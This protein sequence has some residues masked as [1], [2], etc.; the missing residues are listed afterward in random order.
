MASVKVRRE[1]VEMKEM[2]MM[3]PTIELKD[4][5]NIINAAWN[6]LCARLDLDKI[7]IAEHRWLPFNR[8]LLNYTNRYATMTKEEKERE[9][10]ETSLVILPSHKKHDQFNKPVLPIFNAELIIVP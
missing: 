6:E 5:I 1:I 2:H 9:G 4:I 10:S 3:L 7:V 8:S